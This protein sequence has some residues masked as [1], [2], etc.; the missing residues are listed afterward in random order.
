ML[1]EMSFVS[2]LLFFRQRR[3]PIAIATI[4]SYF[5]KNEQSFKDDALLLSFLRLILVT[6]DSGFKNLIEKRAEFCLSL[7]PPEKNFSM[8]LT[9]LNYNLHND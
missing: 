8:D 5:V 7:N 3:F 2:L 6:S 9:A 4:L 1:L